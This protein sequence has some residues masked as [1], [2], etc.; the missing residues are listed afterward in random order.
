MAHNHKDTAGGRVETEARALLA[1]YG[2]RP[3]K[4][5]TVL[6]RQMAWL[7]AGGY[8]ESTREL[9]ARMPN[10]TL[11]KLVAIATSRH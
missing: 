8:G 11:A 1:G 2:K 7:V 4:R 9:L 10:V 6:R 3:S 5:P